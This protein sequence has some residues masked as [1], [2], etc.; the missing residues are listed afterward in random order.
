M[1][2]WWLVSLLLLL[3]LLLLVLLWI[4]VGD[5]AF[6]VVAGGIGVVDVSVAFAP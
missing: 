1:L 5:V 4:R 3:A 6:P 2:F